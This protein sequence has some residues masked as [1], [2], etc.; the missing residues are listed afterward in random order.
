MASSRR[1]LLLVKLAV[2]T[3]RAYDCATRSGKWYT[4]FYDHG[5]LRLLWTNTCEIA[6]GVFRSNQPDPARLEKLA[7]RGIKTIVNLRGTSSLPQYTLEKD[8]CAAL[9]LALID[10]DGFSARSAPIRKVLQNVIHAMETAEKPM[11]F[12][13][14]SGA[15]RTSLAAVLYLLAIEKASIAQARKQLSLRFIH[16][17]WTKTG[18]LDRILDLYETAHLANGASFKD[19]LETDYDHKQIQRDFDADRKA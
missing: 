6:P 1:L 2:G 10:V 9:G 3:A 14:K 16:L 8:T 7:A 15:D 13:C 5:I 19:W 12:H 17:K 11:V 4:L 18:V